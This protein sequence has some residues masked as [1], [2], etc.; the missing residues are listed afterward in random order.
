MITLR[1]G[2]RLIN[3]ATEMF[4]RTGLCVSVSLME[5][6]SVRVQ[7]LTFALQSEIPGCKDDPS[8]LDEMDQDT[9]F[10]DEAL[11]AYYVLVSYLIQLNTPKD[12]NSP[13][14]MRRLRSV[15]KMYIE[16]NLLPSNQSVRA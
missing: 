3:S 2:S 12:P 8:K 4:A 15:A 14:A 11:A 13:L 16:T 10:G 9:P 7:E 5:G 6:F 1:D